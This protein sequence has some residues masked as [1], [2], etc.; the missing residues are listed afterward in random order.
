MDVSLSLLSLICLPSPSPLSLYQSPS[1]LKT[2]AVDEPRGASTF[3]NARQILLLH[4]SLS[5][6]LFFSLFLL[7]LFSLAER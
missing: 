2:N 5:L 4:L 6:S 1:I 7:S 3:A